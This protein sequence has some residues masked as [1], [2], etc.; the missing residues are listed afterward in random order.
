VSSRS[1]AR[2]LGI[3]HEWLIWAWQHK[4]QAPLIE[5]LTFASDGR[6]TYVQVVELLDLC[7]WVPE[8]ECRMLL[9]L[10]AGP[11]VAR[12]CRGFWAGSEQIPGRRG[13][14][15]RIDVLLERVEEARQ[16]MV[17]QNLKRTKGKVE[18][19]DLVVELEKV[20]AGIGVS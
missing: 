11:G 2:Y 17:L 19:V 4:E 5:G 8:N 9:D 14:C 1:A 7:Q 18:R 16:M 13:K 12:G 20:L 3:S 10:W 15:L 6:A